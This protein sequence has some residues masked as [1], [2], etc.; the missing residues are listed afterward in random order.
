MGW[1]MISEISSMSIDF[2]QLFHSSINSK[3]EDIHA[4]DHNYRRIPEAEY[5]LKE[6]QHERKI[7][8]R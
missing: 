7:L 1:T 2:Y 4:F 3:D 8:P 6:K 5:Q